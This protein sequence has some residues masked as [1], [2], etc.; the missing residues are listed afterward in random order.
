LLGKA[1]WHCVAALLLSGVTLPASPGRYG[2]KQLQLPIVICCCQ[3]L[4]K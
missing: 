3:R 1:D 2:P 4:A